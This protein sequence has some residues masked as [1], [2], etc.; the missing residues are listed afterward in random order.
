[1]TEAYISLLLATAAAE[2]PISLINACWL[3]SAWAGT[4]AP[5]TGAKII[6]VPATAV[7]RL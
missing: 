5:T 2:F 6:E 4:A 3:D 7:A 1:M